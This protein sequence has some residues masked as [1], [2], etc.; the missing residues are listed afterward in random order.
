MPVRS[1]AAAVTLLAAFFLAAPPAAA[2]QSLPG[3]REVPY[4]DPA[5]IRL[6]IVPQDGAVAGTPAQRVT[7]LAEQLQR[8]LGPALP[9]APAKTAKEGGRTVSVIARRFQND[10]GTVHMLVA[11]D[12]VG[13]VCHL[14]APATKQSQDALPGALRRCAGELAATGSTRPP[15]AGP[16]PG[17]QA[18]APRPAPAPGGTAPGAPSRNWAAV[19]GVYFRSASSFGVGGM[20]I[21]EFRPLVL[22]RDGTYYEIDGRPLEDVDLA[23]ERQAH[24]RRFGR[25]TRSGER[26]VL[27]GSNGKPNDYALQGGAFF[28]A[29]AAEPGTMLDRGYKRVSGGGNTAMGGEMMIAVSGKYAFTADGRFQQGTSVGAFNSGAST[30]V[31]STVGSRRSAAPG[32]YTLDRHTLTLRRPG[33]ST[34]RVF[35]AF[36]SRKNPP[37]LSRDMIFIGDDGYTSDD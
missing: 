21:I 13:P 28:K 22:F 23:A 26:F 6:A 8:G 17:G 32:S 20:A 2:Q 16:Q 24:P 3:A 34:K 19:E 15:G 25:W 1:I 37:Q 5:G 9:G 14:R 31:A 35:F 18:A 33:G 4:A 29:F 10:P 11:F 7:A 36:A 27:T 30:G 12:A